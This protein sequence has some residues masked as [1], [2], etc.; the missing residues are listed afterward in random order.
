MKVSRMYCICFVLSFWLS[1]C[2]NK[3]TDQNT[4][5]TQTSL[6]QLLPKG[7]SV[8]I[9][10]DKSDYTLSVF[11][12]DTLVKQ[13][14]VVFGGNP[15]D[16]KEKEG[17]K[18]TPEGTFGMRDKYPHKSWSKFIWIDYPNA[19]SWKK[20]N[21]R[22]AAGI[23]KESETIGGEVGIHGV[24]NGMDH[25]IDE[26]QNWTLG[27]ISMKN[28]DVNELYPYITKKTQIIIQK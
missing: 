13:Y 7:T 2:K 25:V 11:T 24:P 10:I 23:I 1:A 15:V 8:R 21:A 14:A 12:A 6:N 4:N 22:K 26:K 5:S 20:F 28:K 17:D 18:R 27:C 16:D 3:T 19:N 9:L